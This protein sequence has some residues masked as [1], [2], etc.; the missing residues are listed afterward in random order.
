MWWKKKPAPAAITPEPGEIE[1][2]T[3]HPGGWVYRIAG[4]Y[5]PDDGVPPEAIAGAWKVDGT[6]QIV[7][8]FKPNPNF[9]PSSPAAN[10]R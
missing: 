2:A 4:N 8:D 5:G 10:K 1:E 3:R 6:G 7:G 9:D